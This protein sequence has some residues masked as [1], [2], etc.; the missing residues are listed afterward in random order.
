M[1]DWAAIER[2]VIDGYFRF[3]PNHARVA[4]DHNFDGVVGDPSG[5]TIQARIEEIDRQLEKLER[6]NGLSPDQA[7]DR[8]GLVVQLKTSRLE[9]T[10]LGRP[11]N[12]P[13]FYTGF[14]SELDVSS[15]LKRP[16]AP[17]GERLKALRQHLAGYSGYLEAA[18]DNLEPSLPR[19][20]LEIAIEAAAG[21]ADY[22]D[23]EVRTAAAGDPDTIRAIDQAVVEIRAAV[24]FLKKGLRDAH[25]HFAL[26][27]DRFM[28]LLQT[29]EMV[30]MSVG[31]LETMVRA[32]I[33]RNMAAAQTAA[34][35]I[36][37]G[38]G[39]GA[40]LQDLEEHHPTTSGQ[41]WKDCAASS[42]ITS[43]SP[44]HLRIDAWYDRPPHTPRISVPLWIVPGR[45][46]PSPP[47]AT[48][49]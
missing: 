29:R 15:Y 2:E 31:E 24:E 25:D 45:W 39:V 11:F 40:A 12:E 27:E 49:T 3:S 41:R 22:L 46:K 37:P 21:Q 13:M 4:G 47:K 38:R 42:W 1:A 28:R 35:A 48:T 43:W 32:D 19:P 33:E 26:G 6:L 9:L 7:A 14:D 8:Q 36:S 10:E 5:T 18:R 44:S 34:D 16:Y 17:I 20:N 30:T 23:G